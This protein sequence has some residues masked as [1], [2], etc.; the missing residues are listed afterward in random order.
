MNEE[1]KNQQLDENNV[2]NVQPR[3]LEQE[4]RE[5]YLAY[6][7]SVIVSR[8]LPDVRDGLK[9]VHRR[10]LYAM[11]EIGLRS[12][13]KYRKSATVVGDVLGKYHPHG[14]TAVYDTM[15][16]MAQDFSMRYPLVDGQGNFGSMDGDSAAAMRY[17][18][19]RMTKYAEEMLVDIEKDT[20]DFADNYDGSRREP[21]V[22]PAKLPQLLLNG[23]LGIAVGMATDIPPHNLGELVDGTIAIINNPDLTTDQLTQ[24]IQGPDFPTGG[25]V[26]GS[27]AVKAAYGTGKGKIIIRGVANIEEM[28]SNR[29]KIV[30]SEIPYR[31]NKANLIAKIA[32][33]VKNKKIDGISD[34]RDESDRTEGVRVV[35]EL[36]ANAYAKK[37]LNKLY[38][39]T[40]LQVSYHFNML[41]LVDG[42][43]PKTLTL[44]N[45]LDEFIKHREIVVTR[46]T[47]YDLNKAKERAHILEGLKKALDFIDQVIDTIRNS[48]TKEEAHK[49]LMAKFS[50][51]DKQT[52]AI[53]EMK[54]STLAGLERKKILDELEEKNNIIKELT[55]IL[56]DRSK[57]LGIIKDELKEIKDKYND[58]R[59]TKI[60]S[61]GI[62]EF[63][64][65]DL[66]PN[67]QVVITITKDNYI[68][69]VPISIY[70]SQKRGGKGKAGLTTK[71]TDVVQQLLVTMTHDKMLFF[72]DKGRVFSTMVY[73]IPAGSRQA[74]GQALV[75][76]L[77][78][79]P[80][81]KITTSICMDKEN[82]SKFLFMATR[83]G[84]VKKTSLEHFENIR[85][86]GIVA[87]KLTDG[88]K[89]EWVFRTTGKDEISMFTKN[90]QS[91]R[92]NEEEA[93]PMGRSASGVRGIKLRQNDEVISTTVVKSDEANVLTIS[94]KG[95]GKQTP[96]S[97][98]SLQRRGGIGLRAARVTA[99]TGPII[100]VQM[101]NNQK[102]DTLIMSSKGI[103]L[104]TSIS[105]IKKISRDTQ[106]VTLIK[107]SND[108]KVASMTIIKQEETTS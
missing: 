40:D 12:N 2:G 45:I 37:V 74:K 68:K 55:A 38:Q 60:I 32:D 33:L 66:V 34:L 14:D 3:N 65:E 102:D 23:T 100:S 4:M 43:Q 6:A 22:L 47:E 52:A 25:I 59:R 9:P 21:I 26:Y 54:L 86:T 15:V 18:E 58:E 19:A 78:L 85:K 103:V 56:A 13:V 79:M 104:R 42:I 106:G 67:E 61:G 7:M 17:T 82:E 24:Y 31:V 96:I 77:Q 44:K 49:N 81:E 16:R 64:T 28:K 87:I 51:T 83:Q 57:I 35:V 62:T 72:S 98:F 93:R 91:I 84:I 99:K 73:D 63:K 107:I 11:H 105:S 90:G 48:P 50:L 101:V 80:N 76:F 108:D 92:F 20:V 41:A 8:A 39:L 30:I 75:N 29:Y 1:I 27:E 5:S 88:D 97:E 36:K 71:E 94:E 95:F 46:R 70:Q 69:R 53:L 10:V 89:L